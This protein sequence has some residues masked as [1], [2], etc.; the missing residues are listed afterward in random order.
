M[1]ISLQNES[2]NKLCTY[3]FKMNHQVFLR[4][5]LLNGHFGLISEELAILKVITW[6][7]LQVRFTWKLQCAV[8]MFSCLEYRIN[9][10]TYH[11]YSARLKHIIFC[12]HLKEFNR[13]T[14]IRCSA[15]LSWHCILFNTCNVWALLVCHEL[16]EFSFL[17]SW[18]WLLLKSNQNNT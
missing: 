1:P 3:V 18:F 11:F 15:V 4:L 13:F 14:E 9:K 17:L 7:Y 10:I 12:V 2:T 16:K 5:I 8:L 6:I